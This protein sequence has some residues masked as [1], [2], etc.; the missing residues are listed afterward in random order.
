MQNVPASAEYYIIRNDDEDWSAKGIVA[1]DY[2]YF[3]QESPPTPHTGPFPFKTYASPEEAIASKDTYPIELYEATMGKLFMWNPKLLQ[4]ERRPEPTIECM[5]W[6]AVKFKI[7][8]V[9]P[10]RAQAR[11]E[12]LRVAG[13][14]ARMKPASKNC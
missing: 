5:G 7:Y 1:G 10:E 2:V 6:F 12:A 11:R 4:W 3:K 13:Q 14:K 8:D 9:D